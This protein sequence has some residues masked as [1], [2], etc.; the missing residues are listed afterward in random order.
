MAS[1]G[2]FNNPVIDAFDDNLRVNPPLDEAKGNLRKNLVANG[3]GPW[4]EINGPIG[5]LLAKK[6]NGID[7]ESS[8]NQ[9]LH[10]GSGSKEISKNETAISVWCW[11]KPESF[12]TAGAIVVEDTEV[13]GQVRL[14]VSVNATGNVVA[15]MRDASGENTATSTATLTAGTLSGVGVRFDT[16]ADTID[17]FIDGVKETN[18]VTMAVFKDVTSN[19]GLTIGGRLSGGDPT[20]EYDGIVN[21]LSL[22][23]IAISDNAFENLYLENTGTFFV[24]DTRTISRQL[25]RDRIAAFVK[26]EGEFIKFNETELLIDSSLIQVSK[27]KPL[28]SVI[29][30]AG[31]GTSDYPMPSIFEE[32]F[33]DIS[34][35]EVPAGEDPPRFRKRDDSWFPYD[36]PTQTPNLRIRFTDIVPSDTETIRVCIKEPWEV[37]ETSSNVKNRI[38]G[39]AIVYKALVFHFRALAAR[40]GQTTDSSIDAD[41]VD[42]GGRSQN[43]LFV[44]D[45]Y[46]NQYKEIVGLDDEGVRAES[47]LI[48]ADRVFAHGEDYLYHDA[49]SR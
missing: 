4:R 43:F 5:A 17:F 14:E 42:Y 29:D 39:L 6:N 18:S 47:V 10:I 45:Q 24:V 21:Q 46:E 16:D 27:D 8:S 9:M 25:L 35:I 3:I 7:F 19:N 23:D 30:I 13:D 38:I 12:P 15:K 22:W 32:G 34:T 33:S 28:L 40:F 49:K 20:D 41:A 36:D 1:G 48:E 26:D 44:A 37:T 2:K 11:T 31:D